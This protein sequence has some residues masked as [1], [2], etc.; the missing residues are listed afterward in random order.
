[1]L[2]HC[3]C[4]FSCSSLPELFFC[5]YIV[6]DFPC[7]TFNV[8]IIT[9]LWS[10]RSVAYLWTHICFYVKLEKQTVGFV[11]AQRATPQCAHFDQSRS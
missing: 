6:L 9:S 5:I 8:V 10:H 7:P 11:W 4:D 3:D 1:M 2:F